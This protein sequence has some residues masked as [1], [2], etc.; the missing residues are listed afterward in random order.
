M[1]WVHRSSRFIPDPAQRFRREHERWLT[2]A[3]ASG[4]PLPRIPIRAISLGGFDRLLAA[5]RG[6]HAVSR[7]WAAVLARPD[8]AEPASR[9][10]R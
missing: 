1:R 5:P 2:R 3:L 8:L 9:F 4:R 7:W 10:R 6:R